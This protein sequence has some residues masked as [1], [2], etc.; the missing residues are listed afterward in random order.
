[1]PARQVSE[2]GDLI[3]AAFAPM[4]GFDE[5][6]VHL[7]PAPLHHA[8][9]C[10]SVV[11]STPSAAPT[12]SYRSFDP[13]AA[14]GYVEQYRATHS[15]WVPTMFVRMLKLGEE[16]RSAHDL[17]SLKVAVH[18]SAPCPVDVKQAPPVGHLAIPCTTPGRPPATS[19]GSTR[20]AISTS[21]TAARS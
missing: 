5:N 13:V 2:P 20:R 11:S 19:A 21:P 4:Y 9:R 12:S 1:M 6:T 7:S 3:A 15:Q 8:A 16:E 14:L 17:S 18:A 10:A